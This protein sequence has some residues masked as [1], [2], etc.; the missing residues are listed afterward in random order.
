MDSVALMA[1]MVAA[2]SPCGFAMLPAYLSFFLGLEGERVDSRTEAVIARALAVGATMTAGVL[3]VF[4]PIGVVLSLGDWS[5]SQITDAAKWPAVVASFAVIGLGVALLAGWHLPWSTPRLDR[6]GSRRTY[7]SIAV[8][9]VSYAVT[10]L[11]CSLPYFLGAIIN[12]F[13]RDGFG[14]GVGTLASYGLGMGLLI[15]ALTVAMASGQRGLLRVLRAVMRHSNRVAGVFLILSGLYLL[16]YWLVRSDTD[17]DVVEELAGDV[18]QFVYRQGATRMVLVLGAVVVA[19]VAFV[20][21]TRRAGPGRM[22]RTSKGTS[23]ISPT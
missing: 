4:V 5:T 17:R 14:S 18:Q 6:G 1:G 20:V 15:T 16:W 8:F 21:A 10:S 11:S 19:G 23:E 2:V 22:S 13:D 3:A 12:S 7:W 9:G